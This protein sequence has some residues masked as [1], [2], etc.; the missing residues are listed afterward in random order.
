MAVATTNRKLTP[1]LHLCT[2]LG[3]ICFCVDS[4]TFKIGLSIDPWSTLFSGTGCKED[5]VDLTDKNGNFPVCTILS[6]K[7]RIFFFRDAMSMARGGSSFP[8]N[9][10]KTFKFLAALI[11]IYV[12]GFWVGD[13]VKSRIGAEKLQ[14]MKTK[15]KSNC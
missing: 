2:L 15:F 14:F 1:I 11:I 8:H 7:R 6:L 13:T 4:A 3:P 9:G 5:D 12:D 10:L